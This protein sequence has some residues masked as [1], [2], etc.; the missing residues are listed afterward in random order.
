[1][2]PA[3]RETILMPNLENFQEAPSVF[4]EMYEHVFHIENSGHCHIHGFEI[5]KAAAL[6]QFRC[7]S[8]HPREKAQGFMPDAPTRTLETPVSVIEA[9]RS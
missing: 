6:V 4:V 5:E 1:M 8:L 2:V 3:L 9:L 7:T